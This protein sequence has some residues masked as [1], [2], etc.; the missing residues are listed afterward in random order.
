MWN[1]VKSIAFGSST[2]TNGRPDSQPTPK[3]TTPTSSPVSV[4]RPEIAMPPSRHHEEA[5]RH[6]GGHHRRHESKGSSSGQRR[7]DRNDGKVGRSVKSRQGL[8]KRISG[9]WSRKDSEEEPSSFENTEQQSRLEELER[10]NGSLQAKLQRAT[11]EKRS[12]EATIEESKN[13]LKKATEMVEAKEKEVA[14]AQ[15]RADNAT[16]LLEQR[17]NESRS[18]M[19]QQQSA[20]RDIKASLDRKKEECRSLQANLEN[21]QAQYQNL[22]AKACAADEERKRLKVQLDRQV[23]ESDDLR[24]KYE[25][26]RQ[27]LELRTKELQGAQEYLHSTRAYSGADL[28]RLVEALNGEIMQAAASITDVLDIETIASNRGIAGSHKAIKKEISL[29]LAEEMMELFRSVEIEDLDVLIQSALQAALA[30]QCTFWINTWSPDKGTDNFLRNIYQR[31][32]L[33]PTAGRWRAITK[34]HTKYA[35]IDKIESSMHDHM[36]DAVV[37]IIHVAGLS[38]AD[39][40]HEEEITKVIRERIL[41]IA[42]QA[43]QIDRIVGLEMTSEELE[44][45]VCSAGQSFHQ[46]S[47]QDV[48]ERKDGDTD[49]ECIAL[50]TTDMGLRCKQMQGSEEIWQVLLKSKVLLET[51]FA[52]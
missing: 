12:L 15:K 50:C 37:A 21:L 10:N 16:L 41:V 3:Q 43:L 25:A 29:F 17:T 48:F 4:Q 46:E 32:E 11:S 35:L 36:F 7:S 27:M 40:T 14:E 38:P 26:C 8:E 20:A 47:M 24:R 18:R 42:N 23:A 31:Q 6:G 22:D 33:S 39:K 49:S 34:T 2:N 44:V 13:E 5:E 45:Y 52:Q 19:E 28:I 51:A 30:Y 1:T 9:M